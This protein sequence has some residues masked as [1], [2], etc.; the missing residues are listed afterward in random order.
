MR[1][2]TCSTERFSETLIRSPR[3]HRLGPLGQPRLLG[4]RH[5]QLERLV[6]DPVLGVVQE[7]P[8]ALGRQPLAAGGVGG[9]QLAQ[10]HPLELA[11]VLPSAFQAGRSRSGGPA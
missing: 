1:S 2:A 5:Q 6:G 10:M 9:E 4:Q 7:Q 3:E 8:R 11:V